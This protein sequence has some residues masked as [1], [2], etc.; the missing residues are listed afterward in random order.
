V[1]VLDVLVAFVIVATLIVGDAYLTVVAT[2][3]GTRMPAGARRRRGVD[4]GMT[5]AP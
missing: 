3:S 1:T 2:R 5:A 4:A